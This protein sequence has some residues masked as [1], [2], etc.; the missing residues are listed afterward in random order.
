MKIIKEREKKKKPITPMTLI[1]MMEEVSPSLAI[2][3][4]K[5]SLM[6]VIERIMNSALKISLISLGMALLS[7]VILIM[8]LLLANA[9][10]EK[11]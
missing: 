8:N 7:I 3:S 6:D 4:E 2:L 5:Y 11:R 9:L 10:V 1:E